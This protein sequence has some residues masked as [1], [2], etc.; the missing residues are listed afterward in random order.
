MNNLPRISSYGQYDSD[1]Y[2]VNSLQVQFDSFTLFYSY[3]TIIAYKDNQDGFVMCKN[4]WGT[5]TGKH[6]NWLDEDHSKRIDGNLFEQ[7]LKDMLERHI[8]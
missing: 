1:N 2:G 7:K 6:M 3:Q 4:S 5:T 8:Q